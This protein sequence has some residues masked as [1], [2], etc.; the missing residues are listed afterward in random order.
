M[1]SQPG[2]ETITIHILH[3]ILPSKG[4]ERMKFSQLIECSK[5]NIFPQKLSRK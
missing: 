5:R 4:N 3:N 2:K 1:T